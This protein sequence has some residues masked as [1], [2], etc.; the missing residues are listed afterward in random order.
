MKVPSRPWVGFEPFTPQSL[1]R[2]VDI[3]LECERKLPL[4][5]RFRLNFLPDEELTMRL[6]AGESE[7]LSV[8]F[9]RHCQLVFRLARRI[10]RDDAEAEDAVQEIFL[11]F[12]R[13]PQKF[14]P[15][16]G[17]FR[18]WLSMF[19]YHR[20]LNRKRQLRSRGFYDSESLDE[21]CSVVSD[22]VD[23]SFSF[24]SAET[25][26]LVKQ[27]LELIN[28]RQRR[29]IEMV[30]FE[31]LTS[32]EVAERTGQSVRV[33]RHHLYRGL[34]RIRLTFR[35]AQLTMIGLYRAFQTSPNLATRY[36][37]VLLC[38]PLVYYIT[39]PEFYYLR[40][41]DPII[42]I[43][44]VYA[45]QGYFDRRRRSR[46]RRNIEWMLKIKPYWT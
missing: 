15:Q 13:A 37:T 14:D 27:A 21:S 1:D 32:D 30:Y 22:A 42:T 16:K 44:A 31:G 18:S 4:F 28:T 39:H 19:S 43:L 8:L 24:N 9:K 11:D 34:D 41:I 7:A 35:S 5:N 10:L 26:C 6:L 20:T 33:V 23:R 3:G 25:L 12:Y 2:D 38:F 17:S 29:V 46:R 40:P 36:A 45:A